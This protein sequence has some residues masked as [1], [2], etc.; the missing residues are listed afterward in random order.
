[1]AEIIANWLLGHCPALV[2]ALSS[3]TPLQ[4]LLLTAAICAA[5]AIGNGREISL[6][7]ARRAKRRA[8]RDKRRAQE[9]KAFLSDDDIYDADWMD[10]D[11]W[12][13]DK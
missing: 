6:G 1:M 12:L 7:S 2:R 3:L 10:Y 4:V 13:H 8:A 9:F 5:L 11:L